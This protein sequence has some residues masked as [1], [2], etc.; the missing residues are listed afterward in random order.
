MF[1]TIEL[2]RMAD[3]MTRHAAVRQAVVAENT[4]NADT[5]GFKARDVVPFA[6]LVAGGVPG[7]PM[8]ATRARHLDAGDGLATAI[9]RTDRLGYAE[10]NG[11]NVSL[12]TEMLK[13]V[14]VKSQHDR[15][16]AIYRSGLSLMR[17]SI[18]RR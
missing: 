4:A 3:A 16:L 5:P 13:A 10:P 8:R 9:T 18:G 17:M 11:N 14:A 6:D 1:E 15:A 2:F 12:E 7:V